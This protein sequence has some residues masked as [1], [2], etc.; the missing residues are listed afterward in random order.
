MINRL[1]KTALGRVIEAT[2]AYQASFASSMTIVAFHR[3]NDAL[4]E[5]KSLTCSSAKFY[6]FC[7]FFASRFRVVPLSEQL[8]ACRSNTPM[9]GTLSITFD[10]GYRDNA[11][12]AAPILKQLG[13]P[14]T[15]FVTTGFIE[16][17]QVPFWDHDLPVQPG[18]MSWE[19]V[20]E[21][22][23]D[24]FDI[25]CHT[26]THIDMGTATAGAIREELRTS[27]QILERQLGKPV[28]LFAYPFGGPEHI[29]DQSLEIVREEGFECCMSCCGGRNPAVPSDT[30]TLKRVPISDWFATPEQMAAEIVLGKV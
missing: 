8:R 2:G 25:G 14:A 1:V 11:E 12:V 5:E 26:H 16:S 21:L 30:F 9:G 13:L 29:R 10:D 4:S 22:D 20:R 17:Q 28:T 18:W 6:D 3:V 7:R 27:K 19:Q 15:F 23:R 24:G